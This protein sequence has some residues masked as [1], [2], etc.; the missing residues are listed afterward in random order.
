MTASQPLAYRMRPQT[1]DAFIGQGQIMSEGKLL[2]RLIKSDKLTSAIFYG[3][4][5]TG[6]TSLAEII[7]RM[8]ELAFFRLNAVSAGVKDIRE[9][10]EQVKSSLLYKRRAC[11]L[12]LDEV[13]RLNKA[14]QDVLLPY[15]ENGT[16][17]LIGATTENPYFTVNSALLSRSVVFEFKPLDDE[18]IKNVIL[19][20]VRDAK[21]G[22]GNESVSFEDGALDYLAAAAGGDARSALNGL[23]LAWLTSEKDAEGEVFIRLADAMES[24]QR[25]L[26]A[27]DRDGDNHYDVISAFIKSMRGS[28]PDAAVY[29]LARMLCSG[30]DPM[31][32]ARRIVIAAAEDVGLANPLALQLAVAAADAVKMI[33]MPEARIILSEAAIMVAVSPKSNS[34]YNAINAAM[35]EVESGHYDAVPNHLRD[36]GYSG[37]KALQRGVGYKYPHDFP[38]SYI[39]QQYLPNELAGKKFYKPGPK[40]YEE[41]ISK[42]LIEI[43][44]RS[45]KKPS[46]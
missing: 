4:S 20:A 17:I 9:I 18:D 16:I 5:G 45:G 1:I 10:G 32:I 35:Q 36:A 31:F 19:S 30:E 43:D 6:K 2:R 22:L 12:F 46:G 7:S 11:M 38:G 34:S 28:D 40:G 21:R 33:G 23:E 29:Y 13:H 24:M 41:Q 26:P 27:Y 42:K 8:T 37:A 39:I 14:Q 25:K 15:V 3:P 44:E